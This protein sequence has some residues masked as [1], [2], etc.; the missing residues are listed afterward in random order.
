M[1]R[2]T[3][4]LTVAALAFATLPIEAQTK[5]PVPLTVDSVT[6]AILGNSPSAS[7]FRSANSITSGIGYGVKYFTAAN[8]PTTTPDAIGQLGFETDTSTFYSANGL[9]VGSWVGNFTFEGFGTFHGQIYS[10]VGYQT[11]GANGY[12]FTQDDWNHVLK[13]TPTS[14]AARTWVLPDLSGT[15]VLQNTGVI[16][17]S[18]GVDSIDL[19]NHQLGTAD[20]GSNVT[21]DWQERRLY[22]T[23][24]GVISWDEWN[25]LTV[26]TAGLAS[27]VFVGPLP[28]D[29]TYAGIWFG[30]AASATPTATS[31]SFLGDGSS[32]FLNAP[33]AIHFQVANVSQ[34]AFS[35]GLF[36]VNTPV[37]IGSANDV[38][39]T[40]ES[41]GVLKVTNGTTG[42]G[43]IKAI[44]TPAGS[45]ARIRFSGSHGTAWPIADSTWYPLTQLTVETEDVGGLWDATNSRTEILPAGGYFFDLHVPGGGGA[46]SWSLQVLDDGSTLHQYGG[47]FGAHP[48]WQ[49]YFVA[50][51]SSRYTF[52][53]MQSS[54]GA[55]NLYTDSTFTYLTLVRQW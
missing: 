44:N 48:G 18:T 53:V 33:T 14:A 46:T 5:K 39:L 47:P 42:D 28:T 41:A 50:D 20:G 25:G 3:T 9:T 43:S 1:T 34:A 12:G 40:R 7:A 27:R 49:G 31:F 17:D 30:G 2:L 22:A 37:N 29:T 19:D 4:L 13:L 10:T 8:R 23:D 26:K 21:L 6:G 36:Q 38:G 55:G 16:K 32:T 24:G 45:H 52:R 15:I 51:G 11:I 54:G 35:S